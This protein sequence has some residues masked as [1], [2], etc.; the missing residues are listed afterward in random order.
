MNYEPPCGES[1]KDTARHIAVMAQKR[2][3]PIEAKFNGIILI[4]NKN[5]DAEK[6]AERIIAF[7]DE[8]CERQHQEYINSD[9]YKEQCR[10]AEEK[11]HA[12]EQK[13]ADILASAPALMTIKEGK[14][15]EWDH[16]VEI[17]KD[18]YS[19]ACVQY[20]EIWA[21]LMESEI[22]KGKTITEC[23]EETSHIADTEGIT[24]FMYGAAV[25]ML[26]QFWI[27][28]EVLRYWHNLETQIGH[29]GEKANETG[30]VLNP[31]LL[32]IEKG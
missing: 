28:G 1:I 6:E 27:H 29:E 26:S 30:G 3:E 13:Q 22:A 32:N 31:A 25:S 10:Q 19:A 14:Q 17:N 5:D 23:A 16:C 12:R 15:A 8:E 24:G 20:A 18:D 11:Q 2:D 21:R 7:Y 9:K 4:A